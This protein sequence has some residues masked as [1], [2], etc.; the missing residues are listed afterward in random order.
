M[1]WQETRPDDAPPTVDD[2]T[3]VAYQIRCQALPVDHAWALSEAVRAVLPWLA[4]ESGAG[5]HT[6][7]V[8]DSGNGWMRP[9]GAADLLYLSRRTRLQ[10]RVPRQRVD[11]AM[12]LVGRTLDVAGHALTIEKATL[13][14]LSPLTTIFS[15][16]VV[17]A[18][19]Q[20]ENAFLVAQLRELEGM[21]VKP[22][23]MLC[24]ME[25]LLATP[26]GPIRTRSLML[27]ELSRPESIRVQRFGLG[28]MRLL[29][30]GLFLPHKDIQ[31]LNP[32]Q[33]G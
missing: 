31:E 9:E 20:D 30:C 4:G 25:K 29:G 6:I 16:Y 27:A 19:G 8:A 13:K 1:F 28:P 24:G 32:N 23:K 12:A 21:D 2:V 22:K 7:H 10:V 5:V 3:D 15:R 11:D 26:D 18:T 17:S 14:P 33:A